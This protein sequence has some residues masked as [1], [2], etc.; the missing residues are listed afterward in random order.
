VITEWK[1]GTKLTNSIKLL[2]HNYIAMGL[3]DG[4]ITW[5]PSD[6][7]GRHLR[8][9]IELFNGDEYETLCGGKKII[10]SDTFLGPAQVTDGKGLVR[11]CGATVALWN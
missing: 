2:W 10:I 11:K 7:A 4:S 5:N 9:V 6:F 1:A 3:E 8:A